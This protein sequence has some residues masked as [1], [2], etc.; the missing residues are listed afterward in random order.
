[1]IVKDILAGKRF[2][3]VTIAPTADLAAAAQLLT[4]HHIGVVV[5]LDAAQ[6]ISGILSERDIVRAIAGRG[7][8]ALHEAVSQVMTSDV[9]TCSEDETIEGLM[10]RMTTGKF[11]HMPVVA[12]GKLSGL[13]SIGDV[14]NQRLQ[15]IASES[16]EMSGRVKDLEELLQ[17]SRMSLG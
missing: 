15:E 14:V 13:V 4:K 16:V 8:S 10:R 5:I 3:V 6:C 7:P 17:L 1:M 2:D 11:R 12:K 9:K